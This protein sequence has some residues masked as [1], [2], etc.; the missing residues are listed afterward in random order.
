LNRFFDGPEAAARSDDPVGAISEVR[1]VSHSPDG[2]YAVVL[3]EYNGS[4]P[5]VELCERHGEGWVSVCG[6]SG[7]GETR[8]SAGVEAGVRTV[9][10]PPSATWQSS[11]SRAPHVDSADA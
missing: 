3:I 5:Y 2:S 7:D 8:L 4:E 10:D 9:W 1:L 6:V 11:S